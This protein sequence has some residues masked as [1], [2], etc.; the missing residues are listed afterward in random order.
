MKTKVLC[1]LGVAAATTVA[2]EAYVNQW[3]SEPVAADPD[4]NYK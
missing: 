3:D 1:L 2:N 4:W